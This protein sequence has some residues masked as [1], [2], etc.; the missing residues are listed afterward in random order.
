MKKPNGNYGTNE[1]TKW[2]RAAALPLLLASLTA[3]NAAQADTT[4]LPANIDQAYLEN[5]VKRL[6]ADEAQ[7]QN[8]KSDIAV[9]NGNTPDNTAPA[10]PTAP[11]YPNLQFH[12]F[13][14]A[15]YQFSTRQG[16]PNAQG[17]TYYPGNDNHAGNS[18]YL[19]ELDLFLQSQLA[20]NISVLNEDVISADPQDN[21]TGLDI[22]RLELQWAINDYLNIDFGRFHTQMGYYNTAYHHGTWFQ[23][24]IA[25]PFFLE[26]EDSG[27]LLPVHTVGVS[28]HGAIPSG[29]WNLSYYVEVG[30]GENYTTNGNPVQNVWDYNQAKS[31]NFALVAKPDWFA[32]GQFGIG[33][34]HDSV[35]PQGLTHTDEWIW[36]ASVAYHSAL[37]ELMAEG[38]I[39]RHNSAAS[40]EHYTPMTYLQVARKFGSYTP[41]ARFTYVNASTSDPIYSA[42]LAE[43]GRQ[44]GPSL[45]LR[46]DLS[47]YVALKLQYDYVIDTGFKNASEVTFQASFTF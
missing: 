41:Y 39:V 18:F 38:F 37:W 17:V 9:R 26:Y 27:G 1:S 14:D 11:T 21:H 8:L 29:K 10:M 15:G 13:A 47:T 23:N 12:G 28:V 42:I 44:Y 19:G 3:E 30:N 16:I 33:A 22:E 46:Y 2:A 43:A 40:G 45:G 25:R 24:A 4:N 32:G 35:N 7:I 6:N 5:L 20:E 31:I 36:N 34:Y